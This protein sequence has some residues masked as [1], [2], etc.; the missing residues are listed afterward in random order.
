VTSHPKALNQEGLRLLCQNVKVG[1]SAYSQRGGDDEGGE[2][3]FHGL[4]PPD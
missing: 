4:W 1:Q 3:V 2:N